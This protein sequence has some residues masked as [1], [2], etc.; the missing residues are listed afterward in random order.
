[1]GQDKTFKVDIY[2]VG[3]SGEGVGSLNGLTLFVDGALPGE[4]ISA[5][6]IEQHK[7]YG[8]GELIDILTPSADRV[9]PICP[10]FGK[11]GGCQLMHL[12]YK[13]QLEI[14]RQKV[15]DA[16]ERIGKLKEIEVAPCIPSPASLAYRNKIQLPI[17]NS[18]NGITLG[19]YAR[20]SHDLIE[21]T[22]CH[23]HCAEGEKVYQEVA[24]E[25]KRSSITA[26]DPSTGKGELRHLLIKTAFQTKESLVILVTNG[27]PS[28]LLK[29][30]AKKLI[31]K[32]SITGIVH[33]ANTSQG[34]AIL[35]DKY[36]LLEGI[37]FIE[38]SLLGLTFKISA[39]SF[40]Q[41][42]PAQA[43]QLYTKA[44]EYA[45][46]TGNETVLDAYCGV[47][48]LSLLAAKKAKKVIGVESVPEAIVNAKEN[49]E[50]NAISNVS[51]VCDDAAHLIHQLDA[52]DVV[53]LN[54][55]RKGCDPAFITGLKKLLPKRIIII[56][57][58][59]ATLAR[60]LALI[61]PLGYTI[62]EIQP[63][64]MFPQTAHIETCLS[65]IRS[66][67]STKLFPF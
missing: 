31:K 65:L 19:L 12:A 52:I 11:C 38:E 48:T 53:L 45:S 44:I 5:R 21:V 2:N 4:T 30:L 7:R 46:L 47:G 50:R 15:I 58:D 29:Q 66:S 67:Y 32:S 6:M 13:K 35:S 41:V 64:D 3:S 16:L 43:E 37:E 1:M 23:I 27:P 28:L 62:E 40:F 49:G 8:R 22:H 55:P 34:N 17:R 24:D 61:L 42:N 56:S 54:P 10:L 57:C 39:A 36:T 60:D 9:T 33:N 18:K 63:F 20:S 51:F 14:K 26:Y 25:I 59:P